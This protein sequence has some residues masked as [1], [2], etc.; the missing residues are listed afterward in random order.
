MPAGAGAEILKQCEVRPASGGR[1]TTRQQ[2]YTN[3]HRIACLARC[4][5]LVVLALPHRDNAW[6]PEWSDAEGRAAK[7]YHQSPYD[8]RLVLGSGA[9]I[10]VAC[11][12]RAANKDLLSLW[13]GPAA[14]CK[15]TAETEPLARAASFDVVEAAHDV[16]TMHA[17]DFEA[18]S[19][20]QRPAAPPAVARDEEEWYW[21]AFERRPVSSSDSAEALR[22][23]RFFW[24]HQFARTGPMRRHLA[25]HQG[26]EGSRGVHGSPL[27]AS[28]Y[29]PPNDHI[30][31]LS[32]EGLRHI[33]GHI[34]A[35]VGQPL[36]N[37][38]PCACKRVHTWMHA[39]FDGE[40]EIFDDEVAGLP[41]TAPSK[42]LA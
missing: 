37:P 2:H 41:E 31:D 27:C 7:P 28:S 22:D 16:P 20:A 29:K 18:A 39:R 9:A 11:S 33:V 5:P 36:G 14:G 6:A 15:M 19:G 25:C 23:L 26:R 3:V 35:G 13:W 12:V 17:A 32:S 4:H 34:L 24:R 40:Q 30:L 8:L 21:V 1:P 42:G 38:L 10:V